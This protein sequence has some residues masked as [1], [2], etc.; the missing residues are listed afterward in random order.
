MIRRSWRLLLP[1][2]LA[3]ATLSSRSSSNTPKAVAENA[4]AAEAG[5]LPLFENF[6]DL[7]RDIGSKVPLVQRCFDQGLCL[8]YDVNDQARGGIKA[9]S[10]AEARCQASRLRRRSAYAANTSRAGML[11]NICPHRIWLPT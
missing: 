5:E 1:P 11:L 9:S 7:H 4:P 3:V 10:S 6:G 8:A 2:L